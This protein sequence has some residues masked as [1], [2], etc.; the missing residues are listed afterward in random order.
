MHSATG[1]AKSHFSGRALRDKRERDLGSALAVG[2]IH[3]SHEAGLRLRVC[4]LCEAFLA[5]LSRYPASKKRRCAG[6]IVG[7]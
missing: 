2:A 4:Q 6:G 5:S 7:I 1:M 3:S